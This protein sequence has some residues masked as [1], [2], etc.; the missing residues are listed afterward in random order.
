ML[1]TRGLPSG[2]FFA[3]YVGESIDTSTHYSKRFPPLFGAAPSL[4]KMLLEM[5]EDG[6]GWNLEQFP[7]RCPDQTRIGLRIQPMVGHEKEDGHSLGVCR[8]SRK[9]YRNHERHWSWHPTNA[10]MMRFVKKAEG[11][12]LHRCSCTN[13]V[14]QSQ[15]KMIY[16]NSNDSNDSLDNVNRAKLLNGANVATLP[17]VQWMKSLL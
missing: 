6:G 12:I 4:S 1:K 16:S 13:K 7:C 9:W 8:K 5:V 2:S 11:L 17:D 3:A 15:R 10:A 14:K